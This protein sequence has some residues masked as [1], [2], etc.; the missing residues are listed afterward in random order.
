MFSELPQVQPNLN[1]PF[2]FT[3]QR[4]FRAGN[5]N[6]DIIQHSHLWNHVRFLRRTNAHT[7]S[8]ISIPASGDGQTRLHRLT[9][10][11]NGA[12]LSRQQLI[13]PRAQ[14]PAAC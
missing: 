12:H 4:E 1:S 5:N 2:P 3:C 7:R 6:R 8:L 14:R 11:N 10:I 13:P 9:N